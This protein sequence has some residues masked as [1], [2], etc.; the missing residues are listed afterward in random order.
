MPS[1][2]D[3]GGDT[4]MRV[5]KDEQWDVLKP[6]L[7]EVRPWA[8]RPVRELRRTIE[9]IVWRQQNGA[10]WRAIP[11]EL[12]PWWM[13]A[14]TFLRWARL[15]VWERL[16][17]LAQARFGLELGMVFLDGTVVRAHQ[18]AA[19]ARKQ[20]RT[21]EASAEAQA[22]GR[23]RGGYGTKGHVLADAAGRA[24]AF[25]VTPG[26]AGELTQ[27]EE[28]LGFLPGTPV[29]TVADRGYSSHALREAIRGLGSTPAIPTRRNEASV[30]CRAWIY[31]NR[32]RVER[33]WSRLKEWRAVAT[34]YEKTARSFLGVLS[35]A[36][37]F[38]WITR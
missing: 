34:R 33:L 38:D 2:V 23:S 8:V 15:G 5:L 16:H 7:N 4:A 29:W 14:Q 20:D 6:L 13:A 18:K 36:A 11:S 37:T 26:Q 31:V 24:I 30:A 28:L 3:V 27:A 35:L 17:R 32:E 19:G 25:V 10:K 21:P 12:G 1:T 9:A 22:L